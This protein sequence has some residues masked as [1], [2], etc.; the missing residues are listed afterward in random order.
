VHPDGKIEAWTI[1]KDDALAPS[2]AVEIDRF[3]WE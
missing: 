3:R 2:Q 1:G